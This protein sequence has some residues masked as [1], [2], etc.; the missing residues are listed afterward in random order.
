MCYIVH[1]C[2]PTYRQFRILL[3]CNGQRCA[4]HSS[5][6][7]TKYTS[8]FVTSDNQVITNYTGKVSAHFFDRLRGWRRIQVVHSNT[9]ALSATGVNVSDSSRRSHKTV[10]Q[11]CHRSPFKLP[12]S[13]C[14]VFR[15]VRGDGTTPFLLAEDRERGCWVDSLV[16]RER[17]ELVVSTPSLSLYDVYTWEHK[18][19]VE[20]TCITNCMAVRIFYLSI[21]LS[22]P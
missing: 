1:I 3:I 17:S 6:N 18:A 21:K 15:R 19:P 20:L 2:N 11:R 4:E 10:T 14:G 16:R 9:T 12:T 5:S 8:R 13:V 7:E 22:S